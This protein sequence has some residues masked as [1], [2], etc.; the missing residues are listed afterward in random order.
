M[1]GN[2]WLSDRSGRRGPYIIACAGAMAAG[3]VIAGSHLS[4]WQGVA[5]VLLMMLSYY[6][7]QGPLLGVLTTILPG[8]ASA[9]AIAFVNMWG[10]AGGFVGPYWMGWMRE[11][12]GDYAVG[13]GALVVPCGLAMVCMWIATRR[14]AAIE[15]VRESLG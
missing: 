13:I 5:G 2:A 14:V 9:I 4:G 6:A 10:I 8:E 12:S 11:A 15:V 7:M 1:L 3:A